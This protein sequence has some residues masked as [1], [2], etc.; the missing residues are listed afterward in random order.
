M[1][2]FIYLEWFGFFPFGDRKNLQ[3]LCKKCKHVLPYLPPKEMNLLKITV[4]VLARVHFLLSNVLHKL[5]LSLIFKS[6]VF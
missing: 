1:S 5:N 3:N 6:L 4:K 2:F